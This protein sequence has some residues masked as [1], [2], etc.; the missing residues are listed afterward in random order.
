MRR[1]AKSPRGKANAR[2]AGGGKPAKD[3]RSRVRDLEERLAESLTREA[4]AQEQQTATRE[5]LGV[6]SSSP[7]DVQPVFETI[8]ASCK[9]LLNARSASVV[10]VMGD[11]L[12]L[13]AFTP[14]TPD[15]DDELRHFYPR[16]ITSGTAVATVARERAPFIVPDTET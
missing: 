1:G 14:T 15:A 11:Q 16:P 8:V 2:R 7:T 10:R 4:E 5:I 3:E 9:R 6:I 13:A 12:H